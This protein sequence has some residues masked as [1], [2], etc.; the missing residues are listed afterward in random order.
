MCVCA[1]DR[2]SWR[3]MSVDSRME[4]MICVFQK[5]VHVCHSSLS[6]FVSSYKW[7]AVVKS[8]SFIQSPLLTV[9]GWSVASL[10]RYSDDSR[11]ASRSF[12]PAH[13]SFPFL[14]LSF[15]C[16]IFCFHS[17]AAGSPW[18]YRLP[19]QRVD[20][21]GVLS[22]LRELAGPRT[23]DGVNPGS[24]AHWKV[25]LDVS[26]PTVYQTYTYVCLHA[27]PL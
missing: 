23:Q 11:F 27:L 7:M 8:I 22:P 6:L 21:P 10:D 19:S 5:N 3:C 12:V 18:L 13:I 24:S 20:G 26:M 15:C 16:P 25:W 4:R 14:S 17:F 2:Y 9:S 1:I